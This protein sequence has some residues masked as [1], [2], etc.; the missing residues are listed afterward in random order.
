MAIEKYLAVAAVGLFFMFGA[1]ITTLYTYLINPQF[2][3]EPEPK[4][5]MF[6]SIGVAPAVCIAG[7][8]FLMSKRYGSR[9]VGVLIFGGGVVLL[10]WM[11]YANTLVSQIDRHYLVFAVQ[12]IPPLFMAVSVPVMVVGALLFRTK[13]RPKKEFF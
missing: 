2:D 6:I 1:E 7:T 9:S 4:I 8:A 5:L 13:P 12:I 11:Y 3:V 10:G